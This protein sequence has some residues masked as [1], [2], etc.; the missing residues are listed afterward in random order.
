MSSHAKGEASIAT[1]PADDTALVGATV[2]SWLGEGA[3]TASGPVG[4]VPEAP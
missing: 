2:E 1:A 3:A 4:D